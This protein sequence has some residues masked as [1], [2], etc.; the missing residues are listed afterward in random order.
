M[1]NLLHSLADRLMG[2]DAPAASGSVLWRTLLER[3]VT[4]DTYASFV[5]RWDEEFF[6]A[7]LR[8]VKFTGARHVLDA[9]C[10]YGQWTL[11]LARQNEHVTA[12]DNRP[13]MLEAT[14][15]LCQHAGITNVSVVQATL[16]DLNLPA[17]T[18]DLIWC[19]LVL[20]YA[21]REGSMRLF[22]KLLRPGGR[23]YVSTNAR[24]RWLVKALSGVLRND[25]NLVRVSSQ[26]ALYGGRENAVPSY[27]SVSQARR[28]VRRHGFE[29]LQVG[30]EGYVHLS[31]ET[32]T[33]LPMFPAHFLGLFDQNIEFVC[34]KPE[35]SR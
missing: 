18:F 20:E 17:N 5:F 2:L 8:K 7:R 21:D 29:L 28:H 14:E 24:G 16:P 27:L 35:A 9:G 4:P 13:E 10:G 1:T 32:P 11:A 3:G 31:D 22:H 23:L 15:K 33:P 34:E 30:N 19:N 25:W 6:A 12:L 26:T